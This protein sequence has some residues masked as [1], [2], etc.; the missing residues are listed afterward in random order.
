VLERVRAFE[1]RHGEFWKPA[2]LLVRLA[3]A[4]KTFA[5]PE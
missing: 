3:E 5:K 1:A 2:P 4:G